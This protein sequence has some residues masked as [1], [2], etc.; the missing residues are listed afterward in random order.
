MLKI[1][2]FVFDLGLA[3]ESDSKFKFSISSVD[4]GSSMTPLSL[5][6]VCFSF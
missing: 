1:G 2:L 3:P 5:S 6:I 4:S